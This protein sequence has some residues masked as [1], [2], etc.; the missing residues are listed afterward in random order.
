MT[1]F[2]SIRNSG[3]TSLILSAINTWLLY[4]LMVPSMD[5]YS[6]LILGKYRIPFRLKRIIHI[7]MDPEQ[8][9]LIVMEDTYGRSPRTLPLVQSFGC[10]VHNGWISFIREGR[11]LILYLSLRGDTTTVSFS[12]FSFSFSSVFSSSTIVSAMT[13][14]SRSS[15]FS[16][17]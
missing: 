9:L 10:F 14:S 1:P 11:L 6:M 7:Q 8:R 17:V 4:N 5:S 2:K 12:P 13:S 3:I 15:S 16:M